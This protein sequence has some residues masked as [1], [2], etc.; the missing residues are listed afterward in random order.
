MALLDDA[1]TAVRVMSDATDGELLALIAASVE[2]MK[3]LGV[4][5]ELLEE[6]SMSPIAKHAVICF[7]RAFYGY[8]NPEAERFHEAYRLAVTALMH[9]EACDEPCPCSQQDGGDADDSQQDADDTT[10]D[11]DG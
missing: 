9:S 5:E 4:R 7:C 1:R 8:D 3:R 2:D 11:G 10:I 6:E